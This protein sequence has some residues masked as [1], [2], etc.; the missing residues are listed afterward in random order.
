VAENCILSQDILSPKSLDPLLHEHERGFFTSL[1]SLYILEATEKEN[2]E[3]QWRN[4]K[5]KQL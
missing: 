5:I 1:I 2:G 3:G 4:E